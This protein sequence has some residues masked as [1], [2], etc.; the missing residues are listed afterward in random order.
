MRR[1]RIEEPVTRAAVASRRLG[2][3]ALMMM[4]IGITLLRSGKIGLQDALAVL[5]VAP[6]IALL[7]VLLAVAAFMWIWRDGCSGLRQAVVG[8]MLGL[9]VLA[10]PGFLVY[11]GVH[12]RRP[13]DVT[14][15]PTDPPAFSRSRAALEARQGI[16]PSQ[17]ANAV[18]P[19]ASS[20]D[21]PIEP[22]DLD[23][24]PVEAQEAALRVAHALGWNVLET[25]PAG[26]RRGIGHIDAVDHAPWLNL[27]IDVTVRLK[28]LPRGVRV[29][30]RAVVRHSV[31]GFALAAAE[32][33]VSRF[34]DGL[35]EEA[36]QAD[37]GPAS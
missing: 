6:I 18:R 16:V 24:S 10:A 5:A 1:V 19:V 21:V 2:W 36:E 26:G 20:D 28:P 30:V 25:V 15:D 37:A 3:F 8:L 13:H 35:A 29:D 22:L 14:T 12:Q 34:L 23:M 32:S 31:Q 9:L 4:V 7:A 33:P 17:S 27:P 11:E